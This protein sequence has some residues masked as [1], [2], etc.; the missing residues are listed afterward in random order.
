MDVGHSLLGECSEYIAQGP[1]RLWKGTLKDA[2]LKALFATQRMIYEPEIHAPE[3]LLHMF[4]IT[5][6]RKD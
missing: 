3:M 2:G 4:N 1:E 5:T 6:I